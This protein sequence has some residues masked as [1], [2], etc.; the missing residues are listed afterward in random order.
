[1]FSG[2]GEQRVVRYKKPPS[3]RVLKAAKA[4]SIS[5]SFEALKTSIR[6]PKLRAAAS[7]SLMYGAEVG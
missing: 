3:L 6:K 5:L 4:L 1:M 2:G 7:A